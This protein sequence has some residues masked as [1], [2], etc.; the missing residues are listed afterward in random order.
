MVQVPVS[1]WQLPKQSCRGRWCGLTECSSSWGVRSNAPLWGV[2]QSN[3]G[4]DWSSQ[5]LR[6]QDPLGLQPVGAVSPKTATARYTRRRTL[7]DRTSLQDRTSSSKSRPALGLV[8]SRVG[9]DTETRGGGPRPTGA[10]AES[11]VSRD[12]YFLLNRRSQMCRPAVWPMLLADVVV[13]ACSM[14]G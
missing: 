3:Q 11:G 13:Q 2:V 5:G 7:R 6:G 8:Q 14:P 1:D 10:G 4:L 9:L 12:G